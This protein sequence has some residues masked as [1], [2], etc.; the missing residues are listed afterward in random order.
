[1][2]N[3]V[4]ECQV[5]LLW[6][7]NG[8]ETSGLGLTRGDVPLPAFSIDAEGLKV[9][10]QLGLVPPAQEAKRVTTRQAVFCS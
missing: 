3:V 5:W 10:L 9:G 6:K 7:G 8:H 1:M 2:Q 4:I